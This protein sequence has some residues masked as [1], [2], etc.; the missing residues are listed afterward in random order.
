MD[1]S[2]EL[3]AFRAEVR[4]F[5]PTRG[6]ARAALQEP[7]WRNVAFAKLRLGDAGRFVAE[8]AIQVHGG[9]GMS[10]GLAAT[11]LT[12]RILMADFER[13]DRHWQAARLAA[14]A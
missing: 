3:A 5:A 7:G 2:A 14:A 12:R 6:L 10:E 8:Q 9:M 13:G 4:E 11:R 1:E